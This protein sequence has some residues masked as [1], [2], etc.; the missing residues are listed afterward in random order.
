MHVWTRPRSTFA[1]CRAL[2][3]ETGVA[4]V[5]G[6]DMDAV[7]GGTFVRVSFSAGAATVDAAV[8]RILA[9]QARGAAD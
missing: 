1:W 6:T 4:V 7:D 3:D 9:F 5:P 2:L 8:E